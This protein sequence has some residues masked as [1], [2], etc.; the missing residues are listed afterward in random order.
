MSHA[1]EIESLRYRAGSFELKDVS[2][3]VPTGSIYGF[4]GPNGSGKTTTMR[5]VLGL[6]RPL[7]GRISVLGDRMPEDA[8]KILAGV[9]YVP[10]QP[11]LDATLTVREII[12]FQSAF[13]PT[14]DR[15]VAEDLLRRFELEDGKLF[16]RL[17]KGQKA[18]L[19]ILLALAQR[20]ELLVLDEPTDGLDPVVRRDILAALLEYVSQR[21][22]TIFISSHL[23]HELERFCD[24][25]AVMDDG[26]VVTEVPME[27]LK[28]GTKR[29]VVS[30]APAT[31][32]A[33]PFVVLSRERSN[34]AERW[35]VGQWEPEM[36][37]YFEGVGASLVDVIDLDLEDGF[38]ELLRSFR[39]AR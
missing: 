9:G 6:L 24:W 19:M 1:I 13:Y 29:L 2:L 5:L 20:G 25:V 23:V 12:T 10:E 7:A 8:P 4:L 17:S 35:I 15:P 33:T 39:E 3:H 18:K 27:K 34:G 37:S 22:A 14:W 28:Q 16:A 36:K 11:H 38:V 32:G 30:G 31:I 21:K 26:R